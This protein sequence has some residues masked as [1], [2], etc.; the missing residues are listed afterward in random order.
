MNCPNCNSRST[1]RVGAEQFYCWDCCVEFRLAR[2]AVRVY[3][4]DA[5]GELIATGAV[6]APDWSA[7]PSPAMRRN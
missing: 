7:G 3:H 2:G 6:D 1:G 5:D 4:V